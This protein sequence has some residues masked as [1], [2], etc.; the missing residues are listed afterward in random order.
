MKTLLT[1]L[2]S[3]LLIGSTLAQTPNCNAWVNFWGSEACRYSTS[4]FTAQNPVPGATYN[5][6]VSGGVIAQNN[7]TSIEV[8]FPSPG[9][10][11]VTLQQLCPVINTQTSHQIPIH[12]NYGS[13]NGAPW[14]SST[15]PD[16]VVAGVTNDFVFT[17]NY[18]DMGPSMNSGT[19]LFFNDYQNPN[20][21]ST[22]L[23]FHTYSG[24]VQDTLSLTWGAQ[25]TVGKCGLAVNPWN[26]GG[27]TLYRYVHILGALLGPASACLGDTATYVLAN[28]TANFWTVMGGTIVAGQNTDTIQVIWNSLVPCQASYFLLFAAD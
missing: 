27:D 10:H 20:S 24:S 26:A 7:G 3:L 12:V 2:T 25:A 19:S 15:G 11:S 22:N 8:Y 28:G 6:S 17:W 18:V 21:I 16:T 1:I 9:N 13:P 5:W 4:T 14:M 23:L